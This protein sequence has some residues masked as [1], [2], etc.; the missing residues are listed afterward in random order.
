MLSFDY[1]ERA[2]IA[3][4]FLPVSI[5]KQILGTENHRVGKIEVRS[6][7]IIEDG[8][9][10][11]VTQTKPVSLMPD[12]LVKIANSPSPVTLLKFYMEIPKKY[13]VYNINNNIK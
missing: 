5:V 10:V 7:P 12:I 6:S 11:D 3:Q 1:Y 9:L 8:Y 13:K 4:L 2:T